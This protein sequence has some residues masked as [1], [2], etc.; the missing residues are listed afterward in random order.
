MSTCKTENYQLHTWGAE[1]EE[2]LAEINENF[3]KLDGAAQVVVGSYIGTGAETQYINL[4]F[5]PKA[6]LV[7]DR[8]GFLSKGSAMY[9]GFYTEANHDNNMTIRFTDT[10]FRA[11]TIGSSGY[12]CGN[13]KDTPYVYLALM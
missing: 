8:E 3:A 12:A 4:G 2:R 11:G 13:N 5:R 10:G 6:L 1:D 7:A 9:G